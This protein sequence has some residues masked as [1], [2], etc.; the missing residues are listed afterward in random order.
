[1]A[2]NPADSVRPPLSP[3]HTDVAEELD[4]DGT[5]AGDAADAASAGH[6]ADAAANTDKPALTSRCGR[7]MLTSMRFV[8]TVAI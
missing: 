5:G 7:Y 8:A 6:A 2:Q 4:V 1:M 3:A